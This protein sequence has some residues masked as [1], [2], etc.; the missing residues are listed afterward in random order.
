[1]RDGI[2]ISSGFVKSLAIVGG[3][4][5]SRRCSNAVVKTSGVI[6]NTVGW[7]VTGRVRFPALLIAGIQLVVLLP[8]VLMFLMTSDVAAYSALLGGLLFILPNAYF[9]AYAFRYSGRYRE[10]GL[11]QLMV[12]AFYRGQFG[13]FVLAMVGFAII[14]RLVHPLHAPAMMA[15]YCLMI[16]SQWFL[17]SEVNKRMTD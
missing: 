12:Q 5:G 11:P 6:A 17:A 9:T 15:A 3:S 16:A 2:G 4:T 8:L 1:M 14:F 13:K 10:P 7:R